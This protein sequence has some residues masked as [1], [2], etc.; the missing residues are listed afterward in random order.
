MPVLALALAFV[1][2]GAGWIVVAIL[3]NVLV[4]R[5]FLGAI[6]VL[7]LGAGLL[8]TPV[9]WRGVRA[10]GWVLRCGP[11]GLALRLRSPFNDDLP[12]EDRIVL[13]IEPGEV[14]SV[15]RATQER[16]VPDSEGVMRVER[17]VYL[18]LVL[19]GPSPPEVAETL[20]GERSPERRRGRTNACHYPVL[21][22]APDLLRIPWKGPGFKVRPG[23]ARALAVLGTTLPVSED[24]D[25]GQQDAQKVDGAALEELLL[26]LA[27]EGDKI[28]AMRVARLRYGLG[29]GAAR[30]F[31]EELVGRR[32]A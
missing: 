31:V 24:L 14:S 10:H 26:Q 1:L 8:V 29:V 16:R 7:T 23:I 2:I 15:R 32:A 3:V 21:L 22:P 30:E 13:R 5:L 12:R 28:G 4:V 9:G 19:R 18:D 27:T 17:R 6:G 11:R 20:A 25:L